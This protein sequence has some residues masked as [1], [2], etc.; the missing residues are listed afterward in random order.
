VLL[1][2][3]SSAHCSLDRWC[4]LPPSE[5]F[6][7]YA[8]KLLIAEYV[9]CIDLGKVDVAYGYWLLWYVTVQQINDC[10]RFGLYSSSIWQYLLKSTIILK[11]HWPSIM[12]G[13]PGSGD[14]YTT[15]SG[16]KG[17]IA[18]HAASPNT[19]ET[20]VSST[21]SSTTPTFTKGCKKVQW[22][23]LA[24]YRENLALKGKK[25]WSSREWQKSTKRDIPDWH[26]S[27]TKP[28]AIVQEKLHTACGAT[29]VTV[30]FT[31]L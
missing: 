3:I 21:A 11:F 20:V 1:R 5:W 27:K 10:S 23:R 19:D 24:L 26:K 8:R 25:F 2:E 14:F 28:L 4:V 6:C 29:I 17:L 31:R 13:N 7:Y 12:V 16:F 30:K 15:D 22:N 9:V 18:K